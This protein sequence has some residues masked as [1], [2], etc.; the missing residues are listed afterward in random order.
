MNVLFLLPQIPY[1]PHSGGRIVTWNTVRRFAESCRVSVVCLYHHPSELDALKT[2]KPICDEVAAF[3][4]HGKWSMKPLLRSLTS[5]WP[6]KAHRFWNPHMAAYIQRLLHRKSFDVIHAQNFYTAAYVSGS[7][8]AWKVHYKENIEGNILLRYGAAS[9]NPL[10]RAAAWFEGRRTRRHELHLCRRFDQI[11]TISPIDRDHLLSCDPNLPVYHQRPGVDLSS[12]PFLEEPEGPPSV[13]FTGT[14]NYYP[15][16]IGA[17]EFLRQAWPSIR[18]QIPDMEC[19]IVGGDPPDGIR[20]FD[21]RDGVHVTGRVPC[22]ED[23]LRRAL[24]YI[25]PLTVGGGIRLKILEAMASGRAIVSTPVGCEGLDGLHGEHL[26]IA[27]L[28]GA[29]AEAAI[30]L[31]LDREKRNRLRHNARALAQGVY[32]WDKVIPLQVE[33]YRLHSLR[34]TGSASESV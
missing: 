24:I 33:R 1:P 5:Y 6:Y 15:N 22:V 21:G 34:R 9:R 29:F 13:L 8:P 2:I 17:G 10:V 27:E 20:A 28:P 11:L 30:D 25:V 16:A 18:E 19:W 12:Y 14:M 32:D 31:A 7:E 26:Q 4:A 3:P 23:Y